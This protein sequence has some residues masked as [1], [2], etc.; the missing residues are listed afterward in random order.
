MPETERLLLRRPR[1][2]DADAFAQ[3]NADPEVARYV[4]ASGPLTRAQSDLLLRGIV[5][6]WDDHGF[7]L[8]TVEPR[9]G[10]PA[11]GFVGLQ[12]PRVAALDG[13]VEVGWRLGR[14]HWGRG[15]AT[16]AA[17]EAVRH[18]FAERR[19]ARLVCLV[20]PDNRA[21]LRVAEKLGFA[22]WREVDHP[23]WPRPVLVLAL[24]AG[25]AA[26]A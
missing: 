3:M 17:A 22:A 6:H 26:G 18:A 25:E 19:L 5:A 13:E 11:M 7:G 2:D 14:A 12:H 20:D 4:S 24:Q 21:S 9:G 1:P 15:Y 16:E 23:R 10:G 8:W